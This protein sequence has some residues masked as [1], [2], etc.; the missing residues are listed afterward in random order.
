M[1]RRLRAVACAATATILTLAVG[2]L[3]SPAA[4]ASVSTTPDVTAGADG[5]VEAIVRSGNTIYIGGAFTHLL[6]PDGTTVARN[7]LAAIDA[8]TGYATAWNPSPN[9]KV[10]S[11]ELSPDG[12]RLYAGGNFTSV[13]TAARSK[14]AAFT[15]SSGIL[16][17]WHPKSINGVVRAV[18]PTSASVYLGGDF[19][20]IGGLSRTRLAAVDPG[21]GA[22][23]PWAP[24]ADKMIRRILPTPTRIYVAGNFS[25]LNGV[26]QRNL[27]AV[28]PSTGATI[29]CA[30]HPGVP[31]LDLT[32]DGQRLFAAAGGPGGS[33][34]AYNLSTGSQLWAVKAD[35][36]VQAVSMF[37]SFLYVGGHFLTIAGVDMVQ[38][39]RLDPATGALDASWRPVVTDHQT[40]SLGVFSIASFTSKLYVGGEF[41]RISSRDQRD[42][43]QLTDNG[44][45]AS[46]DTLIAVTDAPDPVSVGQDVTYTLGV[47]NAGPDGAS[48]VT[49][50][51]V[52]NTD[53]T[54]V[55]ASSGC[56]FDTP[57][58]TVTCSLGNLGPGASASRTITA[59]AEQAG[60]LSNSVSVSSNENDPQPANNAN[61]TTTSVTATA[62]TSDL[63]IAQTP[64]A[65]PVETSAT[66]T[67][68]LMAS[69]AGPD[70][71]ADALVTD[72]VPQGATFVSA[73]A[74]QGSCSG[75]AT[76]IC[77]LG[78]L[79]SGAHA[80]VDVSVRTPDQPMTIT[81]SASI[82]GPNV[83]DPDRSDNASTAMTT[84]ATLAT[85]D[86][87]PPQ[88]IGAQMLDADHDG[89]IDEVTVQFSE[90][91]AT[92]VSPC[93]A[94]WILAN[95][96]SGGSLRSVTTSGSRAILTIAEGSGVQNTAVDL[97]TVALTK[98]NA[99]QDAAGNHPSFGPTA[100]QDR[101]GPVPVAFRKGTGGPTNGLLE[102]GDTITVEWSENIASS[103]V[104]TTATVS[105]S[106]P[107]G[108]GND[109]LNV[110]GLF[111]APM[112]TGSDGYLSLDGASASFAGSSLYL[113]TSDTTTA[114]VAGACA[115]TGCAAL[116][117]GPSTTVTYTA[118]PSLTD[119]AGNA[120]AGTF[121]KT[122]R[123]F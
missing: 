63:G 26:T 100:P 98:P 47:A 31:V 12:S 35:G 101:A 89:R 23:Q 82:D 68:R 30:C 28:D 83:V 39:V 25:V 66:I 81:N 19:T 9:G 93:T 105:L 90:T 3:G 112:D 33:A 123:L 46:A 44:V 65:D 1:S 122:M 107:A 13:G 50:V 32:T 43:A 48:G 51:D 118:N 22:L 70:P 34:F 52:L 109:M 2:A 5:R 6:N 20:T 74:S 103:T 111:G 62:G 88:F 49:A 116:A 114:K 80:T 75:S 8:Y 17:S 91:L 36:N 108:P 84:V 16:A 117:V 57:T 41:D 59:T 42:F 104:P 86:T 85:G 67:Y 73:T 76:V 69:N 119:A 53:L 55:S 97:F 120:A 24:T 71:A 54:F 113:E 102:V 87:T 10:F 4:H 29:A 64:P 45:Q 72:A 21:T 15:V 56:T 40:G 106:D 115:G 27:A 95:V 121:T 14:V 18:T 94:G 79:A 110:I 77:D 61:A 7:Y 92:C 96:P 11:L 60:T 99:I 78:P 58:R 37:G 38:L